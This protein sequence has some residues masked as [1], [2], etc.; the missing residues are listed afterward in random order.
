MRRAVKGEG[1]DFVVQEG[2]H[3]GKTVDF[4]LTP[5]GDKETH[6]LNKHFEVTLPDFKNGLMKKLESGSSDI[7][8]IGGSYLDTGNQAR[9]HAMLNQ[10]DPKY[11]SK[12]I[13]F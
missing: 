13:L 3:A 12:I 7:F 1:G 10:I 4:K 11:M 5:F 2:R 9:L 8:A 6:N